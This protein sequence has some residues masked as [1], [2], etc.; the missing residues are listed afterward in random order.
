MFNAMAAAQ[1]AGDQTMI[2]R[3]LIVGAGF[4]IAATLCGLDPGSYRLGVFAIMMGIL[5]ELTSDMG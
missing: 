1:V 3:A 4:F 2:V 5:S